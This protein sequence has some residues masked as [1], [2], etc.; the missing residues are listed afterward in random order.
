MYGEYGKRLV[1]VGLL[2]PS[3]GLAASLHVVPVSLRMAPGQMA[4]AITLENQGDQPLVAQ[5]RVF[6]WDQTLGED[7][8]QPQDQLQVSPPMARLAPHSAQVARVLRFAPGSTQKELTYRLLID[9]LPDPAAPSDHSIDIRLRYSVPLFVLPNAITGGPALTWHLQ[10]HEGHSYLKVTNAG[11]LHAQISAVQVQNS[12]GD[13]L[14]IATGL[15]GY[16]L[17]GREREW[18]LPEQ[19]ALEDGSAFRVRAVINQ[20]AVVAWLALPNTLPSRP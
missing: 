20:Q 10:R 13:T 19:S 15:L 17:A 18:L 2:V 11:D 12:R 8:L 5:V 9:E 3:F 1:V 6:A 4:A 14:P 16:A 7:L